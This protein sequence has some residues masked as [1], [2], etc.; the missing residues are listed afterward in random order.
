M[1]A[2]R[3]VFHIFQVQILVSVTL[4]GPVFMY[5]THNIFKATEIYD[6][7]CIFFIVKE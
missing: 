3:V 5:I 7:N 6:G 1:F 4:Q 2:C